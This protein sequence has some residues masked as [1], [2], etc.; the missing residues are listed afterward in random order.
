MALRNRKWFSSAA[1]RSERSL[2]YPDTQEIVI[3]PF[4]NRKA[5]T[6]DQIQKMLAKEM[7][8]EA[9][10]KRDTYGF[11]RCIK[12]FKPNVKISID[13]M[14]GEVRG[15]TDEQIFCVTDKFL[16]KAKK[17]NITIADKTIEMYVPDYTDYLILKLMSARPSDIRDIATLVWKNGI[18]T[19]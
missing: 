17:V 15:R 3:L 12:L 5:G 6:I 4:R 9:F 8:V 2:L 16:Q 19:I 13:F 14:E 7:S 18:P 10:E 11:L 1:M